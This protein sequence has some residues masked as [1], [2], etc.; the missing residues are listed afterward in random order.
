LRKVSGHGLG[1]LLRPYKEIEAPGSIPGPQVPLKDLEC[2]RWHHD[3]WYRI[4]EAALGPTPEQVRIDD[5]PGFDAS[6]VSRYSAT[7]PALLRWFKEYN[8]GK[9]Y[10]AQVRPFGFLLSFPSA[11]KRIALR[12]GEDLR[13]RR[14]ESRHW[15]EQWQELRR[16]ILHEGGIRTTA[17]YTRDDIPRSVLRH[18]GLEPDVMADLFGY[19]YV[20]PFLEHVRF[21]RAEYERARADALR[22]ATSALRR[23]VAPFNRD[24]REASANCFD[25]LTGEPVDAVELRSYA[26]V[27]AQYHLSPEHKFL[28]GDYLDSGVT[29]RRRVAADTIEHI[30]KE[31]DRWEEQYYLGLDLDAQIEY[32]S[33][34][35]DA[36]AIWDLIRDACRKN[37]VRNVARAAGLSHTHVSRLC[38]GE[39]KSTP[40]LLALLSRALAVLASEG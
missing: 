28:N 23:P 35:Q 1:H 16:A 9:A 39:F 14:E 24:P 11:S 10:R 37:G 26:D 22:R 12:D 32:G 40:K 21:V 29:Q 3:L 25:R 17:D 34:S 30:G 36:D 13:E 19:D 6:A 18:R 5:R 8:G 7:T 15:K 4:I 38:R 20:D 2:E 31:A 33:S 27:L